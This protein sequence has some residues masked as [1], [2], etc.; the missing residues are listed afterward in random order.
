M[1]TLKIKLPRG[2][3]IEI[4]KGSKIYEPPEGSIDV[5]ECGEFTVDSKKLEAGYYYSVPKTKLIV[6]KENK[7]SISLSEYLN[8]GPIRIINQLLTLT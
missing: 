2:Y 6:R 3:S 4:G 5:G 8:L 1:G 7:D